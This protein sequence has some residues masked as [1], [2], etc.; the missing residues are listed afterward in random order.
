MNQFFVL[1][2]KILRHI[3]VDFLHQLLFAS[4]NL[5]TIPVNWLWSYNVVPDVVLPLIHFI[6]S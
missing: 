3:P 4:Y 6:G 2:D 5:I 1:R